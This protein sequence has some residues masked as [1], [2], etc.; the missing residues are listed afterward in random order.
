MKRND[1]IRG[2]EPDKRL[3]IV[4]KLGFG[5]VIWVGNRAKMGFVASQHA[6]HICVVPIKGRT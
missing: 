6:K 2:G 5:M 3:A 4:E 1:L